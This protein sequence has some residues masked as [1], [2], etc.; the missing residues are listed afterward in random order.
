MNEKV[1]LI[2]KQLSKYMLGNSKI[3]KYVKKNGYLGKS[4]II[5]LALPS[6]V[7]ITSNDCRYMNELGV[8]YSIRADENELQ[9]LIY[10][11]C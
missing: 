11:V 4:D 5:I 6:Y 10:Q 9:V 1:K 2:T 8:N 3:T 7:L